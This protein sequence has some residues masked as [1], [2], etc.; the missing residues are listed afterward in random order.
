MI[1]PGNPPLL[2]VENLRTVFTLADGRE[3]AAV[4]EVSFAIDAGET[5]GL[6]GDKYEM[7]RRNC[8]DTFAELPP[9]QSFQP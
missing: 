5:L 7:G 2:A 4:D 6:V 3:V 9:C 8:P 1:R